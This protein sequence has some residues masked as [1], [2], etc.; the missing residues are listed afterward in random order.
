MPCTT[1][2]QST[3]TGKHTPLTNDR[4][5]LQVVV[6]CMAHTPQGSGLM[7][8]GEEPDFY[9]IEVRED[10]PDGEIH[11]HDE[12]VNITDYAVASKLAEH[13]ARVWQCGIDEIDGC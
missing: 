1:T 8:H 7:N 10:L 11:T 2:T 6:Y 4:M 9:D 3:D 5:N 13:L 12:H